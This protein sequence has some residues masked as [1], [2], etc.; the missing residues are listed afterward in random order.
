MKYFTVEEANQLLPVITREL[1]A[2]QQLQLSFVKFYDQL[3]KLRLSDN[4]PDDDFFVLESKLDFMEMEA[5]S[6]IH[7]IHSF[8]AELKDIHAGLVDFPAMIEN[9]EVLLCW[10]QGEPAITHY[11]GIEEEFI[12]RK[13]LE[14]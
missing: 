6:Y 7:N 9:E 3:E 14:N 11:H 4:P 12:N 2:L 5:Q 1:E 10:R 13:S 8:G